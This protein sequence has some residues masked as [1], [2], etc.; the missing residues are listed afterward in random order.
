M[1]DIDRFIEALFIQLERGGSKNNLALL[2]IIQRTLAA[3]KLM[4]H[5]GK[6]VSAEEEKS[7]S[8]EDAKPGDVLYVIKTSGYAWLILY[9]GTHLDGIITY[10]SLCLNA[11]IYY[12]GGYWGHKDIIESVRI[13]T[14]EETDKLFNK[15]QQEGYRWNPDKLQFDKLEIENT[16]PDA[17]A[18]IQIMTDKFKYDLQAGNGELIGYIPVDGIVA[19]YKKGLEDMWNKLKEK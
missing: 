3:Q 10:G 2:K 9:K 18:F 1:I 19:A 15:I 17:D 6:I 11:D 5:G 13:A 7:W 14:A 4:L 8:I 16:I 12:Y